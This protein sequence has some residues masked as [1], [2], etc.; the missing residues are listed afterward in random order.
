LRERK[1]HRGRNSNGDWSFENELAPGQH[2]ISTESLE[3]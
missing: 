2:H 3:A 1:S